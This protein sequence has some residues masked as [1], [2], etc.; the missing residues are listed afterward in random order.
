MVGTLLAMRRTSSFP[1]PRLQPVIR[2]EE[3]DDSMGFN[4]SDS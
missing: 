4:W 3:A 1:R 2:M